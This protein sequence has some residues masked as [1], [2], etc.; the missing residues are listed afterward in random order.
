MNLF[1]ILR[2]HERSQM[3]FVERR[4]RDDELRISYLLGQKKRRRSP[5]YVVGSELNTVS[6]AGESCRDHGDERAHVPPGGVNMLDSPF[7]QGARQPN[8]PDEDLSVVANR[9][10]PPVGSEDDVGQ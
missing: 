8:G 4:V 7:L 1:S 9:F 6:D 10:R 5:V 3:R 2:R